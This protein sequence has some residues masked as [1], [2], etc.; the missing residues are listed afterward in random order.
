MPLFPL[1]KLNLI[2]SFISQA[3]RVLKLLSKVK[4]KKNLLNKQSSS[5]TLGVTRDL[6]YLNLNDKTNSCQIKQE[7][8]VVI[9]FP[10]KYFLL[11][12]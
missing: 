5:P 12:T 4:K 6:T 7:P 8:C 2:F 10:L 11:Q 1:T 9:D 3:L